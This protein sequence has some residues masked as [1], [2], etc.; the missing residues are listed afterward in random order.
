MN[1]EAACQ[2]F[3]NNNFNKQHGKALAGFSFFWRIFVLTKQ[4]KLN[5]I[6]VKKIC[7]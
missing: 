7:V 2:N 4:L 1:D 3:F 5:T 6:K